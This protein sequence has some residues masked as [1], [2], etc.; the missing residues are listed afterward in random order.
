MKTC[1]CEYYASLCERL[2]WQ[3]LFIEILWGIVKDREQNY[4]KNIYG[5]YFYNITQFKSIALTFVASQNEFI[6]CVTKKN[7]I[8]FFYVHFVLGHFSTKLK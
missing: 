4:A 6:H 1:E 2:A 8:Y 5:N 7:Y 3:N